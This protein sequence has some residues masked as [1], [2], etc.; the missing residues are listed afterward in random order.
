MPRM[1]EGGGVGGGTY[2]SAIC[3]I[4][5]PSIREQVPLQV[6]LNEQGGAQDVQSPALLP[7]VLAVACPAHIRSST[8]LSN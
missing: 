4:S 5:H 2:T 1:G 7:G 6:F 3:Q 8:G